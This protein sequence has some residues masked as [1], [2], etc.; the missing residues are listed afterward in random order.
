MGFPPFRRHFPPNFTRWELSY[1]VASCGASAT[2]R[3]VYR[4]CFLVVVS[5]KVTDELQWT[6]YKS[7]KM[8]LR[9]QLS[10]ELSVQQQEDDGQ[11]D[12]REKLCRVS[13]HVLRKQHRT[14]TL[15]SPQVLNSRVQVGLQR[16]ASAV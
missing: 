8:P 13:L 3:H 15:S 11:E 4:A 12:E 6:V 7:A 9:H 14:C 2:Y 16:A 5:G 10:V 1:F